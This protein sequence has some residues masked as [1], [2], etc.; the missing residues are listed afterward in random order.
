MNNN[1][2]NEK[3]QN[4]ELQDEELNGVSGGLILTPVIQNMPYTPGMGIPVTK[5]L[6]YE[7]GPIQVQN[8]PATPGVL[9]VQPLPA[10]GEIAAPIPIKKKTVSL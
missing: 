3:L 4:T 10:P 2:Q 9:T 1:D 5:T 7:G 6:E 8:M